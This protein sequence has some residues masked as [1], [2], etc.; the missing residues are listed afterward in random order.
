MKLPKRDRTEKPKTDRRESVRLVAE[1]VGGS[2]VPQKKPYLDEVV[3]VHEAWTIRLDG[4][5][6]S[7]GQTVITYTRV[8]SY[9][10]RW[11]GLRVTVRKRTFLDRNERFVVKGKPAARVPSLFSASELGRAVLALPTMRLEV[12]RPSRKSRKRYGEDTGVVVCLTNGFITEV[13]RM[14]GMIR[15][16]Q[17]TLDGL[18]RIGEAGE[19]TVA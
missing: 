2:D 9:F 15:V 17:E 14:V 13:D 7:T 11:R 19:E 18:A 1:A 10:G 5:Y 16:V 8:R 12:K 6:Q 4:Y 3:V